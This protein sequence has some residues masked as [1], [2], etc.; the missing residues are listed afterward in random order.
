V[1]LLLEKYDNIIEKKRAPFYSWGLV[2][3]K[4]GKYAPK[5]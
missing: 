1:I 2:E 5:I 3:D 4:W